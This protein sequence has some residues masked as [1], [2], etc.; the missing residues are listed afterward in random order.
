MA[1]I[2]HA[3]LLL[4]EILEKFKRED[5]EVTITRDVL[6]HLLDLYICCW[7][8]DEEWYLATYPDVQDAI[9]K[10]LFPSGW[11]HFRK[12]GYFEGRLGASPS[13]DTQWYTSAYP[14]IAQAMLEGK[15][16]DAADH[17]VRFGYAEGRL[18]R[19]PGVYPK[20]YGPRYMAY[21]DEN[22]LNRTMCEE[23]FVRLGYLGFAV[24]APPR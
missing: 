10:K 5:A 15:V 3:K 20:W 12:V 16:I 8:F 4:G 9:K 6:M 18:P 11:M 24:P 13:V 21:T 14:D 2:P 23:H 22:M 17:Y 1:P 7:D 19:D